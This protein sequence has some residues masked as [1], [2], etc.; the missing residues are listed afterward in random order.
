MMIVRPKPVDELHCAN[1]E[2]CCP[3]LE[4]SGNQSVG[5]MLY[6]GEFGG[7]IEMEDDDDPDSCPLRNK[8]CLKKIKI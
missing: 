1:T 7:D 8:K 3:C 4:N 2:E 6:C 5:N